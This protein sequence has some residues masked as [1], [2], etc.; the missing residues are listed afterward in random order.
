[1]RK[2]STKQ[3]QKKNL[4]FN[5]TLDAKCHLNKGIW[6]FWNQICPKTVEKIFSII[7]YPLHCN[8]F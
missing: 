7:N 8:H 1:M 4:G 3:Q 6:N 5:F 2:T